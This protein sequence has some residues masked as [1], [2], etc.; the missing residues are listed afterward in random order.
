MAKGY[1]SPDEMPEETG[2]IIVF[3]PKDINGL[4]GQALAGQISRLTSY[5]TWDADAD[6]RREISYLWAAHNLRTFDTWDKMDCELA[7]LVEREE[8]VNVNV[9][10]GGGGCG[11]GCG[12]GSSG[13]GDV[14]QLPLDNL[15][16]LPPESGSTHDTGEGK[17]G[18]N[19]QCAMAWAYADGFEQIFYRGKNFFAAVTI[20]AALV[21]SLT[22]GVTIFQRIILILEHSLFMSLLVSW[23]VILKTAL[24]FDNGFDA[25]QDYHDQFVCAIAGATTPHEARM[26]TASVIAAIKADYGLTVYMIFYFYFAMTDW[27]AFF[28][29]S[30]FDQSEQDDLVAKLQPYLSKDCT[31]CAGFVP[32]SDIPEEIVPTYWLVPVD[33]AITVDSVNGGSGQNLGG[34]VW[35]VTGDANGG[36]SMQVDLSPHGFDILKDA[37]THRW[38]FMF[39]VVSSS[40]GTGDFACQSANNTVHDVSQS[41]VTGATYRG[42]RGTAAQGL[43][44]WMNEETVLASPDGNR[45][46]FYFLQWGGGGVKTSTVKLW[47]VMDEGGMV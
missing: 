38:G 3:Y 17:L 8:D 26:N 40:G 43:Q 7:A 35:E 22:A 29:W 36:I 6:T 2:C 45:N 46:R 32:G 20:T 13:G 11:C 1:P 31:S 24:G 18:G 42:V 12:C 34:N 39:E 23:L 33:A 10:L 15:S 19:Y 30:G 37:G 16:E 9:S 5:W 41:L 14:L 27:N 28:D 4:F 25:A 21:E 44:D 47:I